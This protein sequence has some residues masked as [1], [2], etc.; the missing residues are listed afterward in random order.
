MFADSFL[1]FSP[2]S[3]TPEISAW[4]ENK[5]QIL[6]KGKQPEYYQKNAPYDFELSQ[7]QLL[8]L[9]GFIIQET[10]G[11]YSLFNIY[12]SQVIKLTENISNLDKEASL[13]RAKK[14]LEEA[15]WFICHQS[16]QAEFLDRYI[17]NLCASGAASSLDMALKHFSSTGF[18]AALHISKE[19]L[20]RSLVHAYIRLEQLCPHDGNEI[21]YVNGYF[22]YLASS[23]GC[24][25]QVDDFAMPA[26]SLSE[27]N[28]LADYVRTHFSLGSFLDLL[29]TLLPPLPRTSF[30][31]SDKESYGMIHDYAQFIESEQ[32]DSILENQ[33]YLLYEQESLET[34]V[35]GY[36]EFQLKMAPK[37]EF[38]V[39][40]DA[41]VVA[42]LQSLGCLDELKL[43]MNQNSYLFNGKTF[44]K[45][46]EDSP[47]VLCSEEQNELQD[48]LILHLF[49]KKNK[50]EDCTLNKNIILQMLD[51]KHLIQ[52]YQKA[53][54]SSELLIFEESFRC[55]M[56][57]EPLFK[58]FF[59]KIFKNP[60]YGNFRHLSQ[61]AMEVLSQPN[62][63]FD[64]DELSFLISYLKLIQP[65]YLPQCI[66]LACKRN[67]ILTL[68]MMLQESLK[69]F[70]PHEIFNS[71]EE[72]LVFL[73]AQNGQFKVIKVLAEN[74]ANLNQ[75]NKNGLSALWI[76]TYHGYT[77]SIKMLI[78]LGANVNLSN[79][80]GISPLWIAAHNHQIEALK[81]LIQAGADLNQTEKEEETP[82]YTAA[83]NGHIE[84]VKMLLQ[85]RAHI[86]FAKKNGGTPLWAAAQRGHNEI[87]KCLL[88]FGASI[89]QLG[90]QDATPLLIACHHGHFETVKD[91]IDFGA[92]L[93]ISNRFGK[94]PLFIAAQNGHLDILSL[95]LKRNAM[96]NLANHEKV[97]PLWIAAKNG[98]NEMVKVLIQSGAT[99]NQIN[100][101][102]VSALSIAV[103]KGHFE[104]VKI[105]LENEAN[106]NLAMLD[107]STP[108]FHAA[109]RG[110]VALV[111]LLI[112]NG[113]AINQ[114]SAQGKSP[115]YIAV[116]EGQLEIAK[117]LIESGAAVN[118][119]E[120]YG[121]SPLWI[122]AQHGNLK[123]IK[124]LIEKGKAKVNQPKING[125]SPLWIAAQHNHL[126]VI[127]FLIKKG[128][129]IDQGAYT[130]ATPLFIAAQKGWSLTTLELL[131]SGACP[132]LSFFNTADG[133]LEFSK[134]Q[135]SPSIEDRMLRW[136]QQQEKKPI[137]SMKPHEIAEIMG[138]VLLS[139]LIQSY[140][141]GTVRTYPRS[142]PYA[143]NSMMF[144]NT[145]PY[146]VE[147]PEE[148]DEGLEKIVSP[149]SR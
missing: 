82:L 35:D 59:Q 22:N 2:S 107:G 49:G 118:Q 63:P 133:F 21:H 84:V 138:H 135:Y 18:E 137:L 24:K 148:K 103:Q 3:M 130:G 115:L 139:S 29:H 73:A 32:K 129:M 120:N 45:I 89:N 140:L 10:K 17:V 75:R 39:I 46:Q 76:A 98:Q 127:R 90:N 43:S 124:I 112:K 102:N 104:I 26:P 30:D 37:P 83:Y 64:I 69:I 136:I 42:K 8:A 4:T 86:D 93:N 34:L 56:Q 101:E 1:A 119:A 111:E 134:Q 31:A 145:T 50:L 80:D 38:D 11:I 28:G 40:L 74:G 62:L 6:Y 79:I 14:T 72:S 68:G 81:V 67:A 91:L 5:L 55:I 25:E 61:F 48:Q 52:L 122:A 142:R 16:V 77:K 20:L 85:A 23:Y 47:L 99:I 121:A 117:I 149:A 106:I 128:A 44:I 131:V 9:L 88:S 113:A 57:Q 36:T 94:T 144:S 33:L 66:L 114:A 13:L 70:S 105:L 27:L 87:I 126:E 125:I 116:Q 12:S 109:G 65:S 92:A 53:H 132:H 143:L 110:Y 147:S 7:Q 58:C 41:L 100:Y 19:S 123:L 97:T 141:A 15:L 78:N 54:L 60:K 51:G 96:V 108:L 146:W 71:Q 95:L